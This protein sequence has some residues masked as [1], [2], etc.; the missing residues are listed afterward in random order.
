MPYTN[1][2]K[3]Y[4]LIVLLPL[5]L[6]FSIAFYN[7]ATSVVKPYQKFLNKYYN[8]NPL[9]RYQSKRPADLIADQAP[10]G[11][12]FLQKGEKVFINKS[13]L[14]FKGLSHGKINLDLY[15]LELDPD[16]PYPL[17]L[18]KDSLNKGIWIGDSLYTLVSVKKNKLHLRIQDSN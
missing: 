1:N 7:S 8:Q 5:V 9:A 2:K 4:G 15:V 10:M 13:C 11:Q 12:V 14:V 6:A 16:I 18:T 3:R 17:S